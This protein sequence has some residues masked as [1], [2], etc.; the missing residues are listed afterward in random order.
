MVNSVRL[1]RAVQMD[2]KG[3]F[4][5]AIS[6]AL[7]ILRVLT[8]TFVRRRPAVREING[9]RDRRQGADLDAVR[10]VGLADPDLRRRCFPCCRLT[11]RP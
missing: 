7:R 3:H 5:A 1:H 4:L 8:A 11:A 9:G 10:G 6:S 2:R